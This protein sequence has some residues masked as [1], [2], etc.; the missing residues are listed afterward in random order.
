[1]RCCLGSAVLRECLA[2]VDS[3]HAA[4][5]NDLPALTISIVT[6]KMR[7][8]GRAIYCAF[9]INVSAV[10]IG[11]RRKVLDGCIASIEVEDRTT[12]HASSIGDENIK[13]TP[14]VPNSLKELGLR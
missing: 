8:K 5:D 6:H 1:M 10:G 14:L 11:L 2:R 12:V 4:C 9:Q 7:G 3:D 13:A